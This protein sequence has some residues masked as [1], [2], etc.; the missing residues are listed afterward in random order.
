MV[1]IRPRGKL[2]ECGN[3]AMHIILHIFLS[4]LLFF[5]PPARQTGEA[6]IVYYGGSMLP[7]LNL[8]F[9]GCFALFFFFSW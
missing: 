4:L 1:E 7:V 6:L 5:L 9:R 2:W 3:C 8:E